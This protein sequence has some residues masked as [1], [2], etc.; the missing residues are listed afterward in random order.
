M[1]LDSFVGTYMEK[2]AEELIFE[3]ISKNLADADEY[4]GKL[5]SLDILSDESDQ[6]L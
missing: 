4:P 6:N 5:T 1:V 3:N 2:Q